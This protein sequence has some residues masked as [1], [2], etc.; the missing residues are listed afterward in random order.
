[1]SKAPQKAGGR[2]PTR[3]GRRQVI[4]KIKGTAITVPKQLRAH[5]FQATYGIPEDGG[6]RIHGETVEAQTEKD[7]FLRDAWHI[8]NALGQAL[9]MYGGFSEQRVIKNQMSSKSAG[10]VRAAYIHPT[11][12]YWISLYIE[13]DAERTKTAIPRSDGIIVAVCRRTHQPSRESERLHY[14]NPA[15]DTLQLAQVLLLLVG[16]KKPEQLDIRDSSFL[17]GE[18]LQQQLFGGVPASGM[19]LPGP[20][21]IVR[22]WLQRAYRQCVFLKKC[23]QTVEI[24]C[25]DGN[26]LVALPYWG[27]RITRP[28]THVH[29]DDR[30]LCVRESQER[31]ERG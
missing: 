14:L 18:L 7:H 16:I 30:G 22:V 13:V 29:P 26:P 5:T 31:Q 9:A 1:M 4:R 27:K 23:S 2:R 15:M 19:P 28:L 21:I 6:L 20:G 24:V 8:A 11:L 17:E 10:N 3:K 25:I 12:P